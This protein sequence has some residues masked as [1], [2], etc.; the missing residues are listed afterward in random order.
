MK[1]SDAPYGYIEPVT[2]TNSAI[3]PL[4]LGFNETNGD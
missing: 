2:H 1:L 4:P 3:L